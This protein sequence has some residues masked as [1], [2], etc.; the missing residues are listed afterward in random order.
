MAKLA[1][2]VVATIAGGVLGIVGIVATVGAVSPSADHVASET[3]TDAEPA[4]YGTR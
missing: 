1:T 2:F 3:S 4:V